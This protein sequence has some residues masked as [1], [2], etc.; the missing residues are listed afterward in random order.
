MDSKEKDPRKLEVERLFTLELPAI[1][2]LTG[3]NIFTQSWEV[4][5]P[6]P[7]RPHREGHDVFAWKE[8]V[9]LVSWDDRLLRKLQDLGGD[10][11]MRM[12]VVSC[13]VQEQVAMLNMD[14]YELE[15]EEK[16]ARD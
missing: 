14:I 10:L 9:S 1:G 2:A 4:S 11:I 15:Q 5:W 8:F 3:R 16:D 7:P 12:A 6:M 13:R